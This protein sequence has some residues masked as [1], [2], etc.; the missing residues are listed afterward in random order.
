MSPRPHGARPARRDSD[1]SYGESAGSVMELSGFDLPTFDSETAAAGFDRARPALDDAP[2]TLPSASRRLPAAGLI[3][4][5]DDLGNDAEDDLPDSLVGTEVEFLDA[6]QLPEVK[7]R[8]LSK[9]GPRPRPAASRP[10]ASRPAAAASA[11]AAADLLREHGLD[12]E[13]DGF[14]DEPLA[15]GPLPPRRGR[16]R[17]STAPQAAPAKGVNPNVLVLATVLTIPALVLGL[18]QAFGERQSTRAEWREAFDDLDD[19]MNEFVDVAH[20]PEGE[21]TAWKVKFETARP[22]LRD[23]TS[24]APDASA[25]GEIDRAINTLEQAVELRADGASREV[26][27]KTVGRAVGH[28]REAA[29]R[30]GMTKFEWAK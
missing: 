30:L 2:P 14:D 15:D 6:L 11:G 12:E 13:D 22:A 29:G 21:W 3:D 9:T 27:D 7:R 18:N 25:G 28:A 4:L 8:P 19:L 24:A 10:A 17:Q 16:R 20:A 5:D 23:K 1:D 26:L